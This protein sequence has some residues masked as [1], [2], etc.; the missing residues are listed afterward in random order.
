M[1]L[2]EVETADRLGGPRRLEPGTRRCGLLP[3]HRPERLSHGRAR[4]P[5]HRPRLDADL[6]RSFRLLRALYRRSCSLRRGPRPRAYQ[7]RASTISAAALPASTASKPWRE[8]YGGSVIETAASQRALYASI[9]ARAKCG[10][11]RSFRSERP[12]PG[13][14]L[15]TAGISSRRAS[16]FLSPGS[17]SRHAVALGFVDSGRIKG[18]GCCANAASVTRSVR[19]LPIAPASP[20]LCSARFAIMPSAVRS[21]SISRSQTSPPGSS[22]LSTTCGGVSPASDVSAG[23]PG[24]PLGEYL[25]DHQLRG[26]LI[27]YSLGPQIRFDSRAGARFVVRQIASL[28]PGAGL[29]CR[30]Y[31]RRAAPPSIRPH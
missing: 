15:T 12:S 24:L 19:S 18:Y 27:P 23:D 21:P 7:R 29:D 20:K 16:A 14:P 30:R 28:K 13:S 25:R 8:K 9:A 2:S 31:R 26:G 6:R 11:T 1:P 5:P 22:P 10:P 17:A 4:R 3:R